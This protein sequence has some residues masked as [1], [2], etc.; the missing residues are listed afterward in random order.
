MI[1]QSHKYVPGLFFFVFQ[2]KDECLGS[3]VHSDTE[4]S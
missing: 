2:F 1:Y 3:L 4:G